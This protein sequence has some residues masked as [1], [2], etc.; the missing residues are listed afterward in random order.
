MGFDLNIIVNTRIDEDTGLPFVWFGSDP[1]IKKPYN[2]SEYQIPEEY[3]KWINQRGHHFHSYIKQFDETTTQIEVEIF[4]HYYPKWKDIKDDI[5]YDDEWNE[6]D[7]DEFKKC[8]EWLE[9]KSGVFGIS[10]SY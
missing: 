6:K 4:L 10:W 5:L 2:P 1:M 8:L 3:R 7:H 9:S